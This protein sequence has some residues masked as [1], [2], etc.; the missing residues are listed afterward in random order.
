MQRI[1][2]GSFH[3]VRKVGRTDNEYTLKLNSVIKIFA[4]FMFLLIFFFKIICSRHYAISFL[5]SSVHISTYKGI[6]CHY[7]IIVGL[8]RKLTIITECR[9]PS[10]WV[11]AVVV[12]SELE[13]SK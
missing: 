13:K 5:Y 3:A 6:L 10:V 7:S 9:N 12:G 1:F 4:V 8:V 2:H 11:S